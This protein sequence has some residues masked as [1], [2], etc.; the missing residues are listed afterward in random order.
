MLKRVFIVG[1]FLAFYLICGNCEPNSKEA[2]RGTKFGGDAW[3]NTLYFTENCGQWPPEILYKATI[4]HVSISFSQGEVYFQFRRCSTS[5]RRR[6]ST[7]KQASYVS[8]L[9]SKRECYGLNKKFDS[10]QV[11]TVKAKLVGS[12]PRVTVCGE[13]PVSYKCNYFFGNDAAMWYTDVPNYRAVTYKNIYPGIDLRYY[14]NGEQMEYDFIVSSGVDPSQIELR[15]EGTENVFVNADG[16]LVLETGI[17]MIKG[18][19]PIVYQIEDGVRSLVKG[20]YVLLSKNTIGFELEGNY[21]RSS[22]IVIDPVLSFSTF[23]GG[24]DDDEAHDIAV[25]GNGDVYI[26]GEAAS[27]NFPVRNAYQGTY[28]GYDDVFVTKFSSDGTLIYSTY[29]GGTGTEEGY[30]IAVDGSGAVYL[31]GET[32]SPDF[33]MVNAYD[34]TI[35]TNPIYGYPSFEAFVTKLSPAGNSL[36]FSTYLGGSFDDWAWGIAVD[37]GGYTYIGGSTES[38]DFPVENA[39]DNSLGGT[40]D[41]FVAKLSPFGNSLVYSTYLGGFAEEGCL[42]M[43]VNRK[44]DVYVAGWTTSADFPV[45][46]AYDTDLGGSSDGFVAR[47]SSL[48]SL[49]YSTY[50]GGS[51]DDGCASIAVGEDGIIYVA[52]GTN[53]VDFPIVN[54]YDP[55]LNDN[56]ADAFV[57]KIDSSGSVIL[58]STYLG[59]TDAEIV[60]DIDVS[61]SGQVYLTGFTSS[62]DFPLVNSYDESYNGS[63]DVFVSSLSS[64]GDELIYSTYL[65]GSEY[66]E[67]DGIVV[68]GNGNVF[69]SGWTLSSDFPTANAYDNGFNGFIDAFVAKIADVGTFVNDCRDLTRPESFS[70]SQNYPNPFNLQTQIEFVIPYTSKAKIEIFNVLGQ[71]I[72]TL[73][74]GWLTQGSYRITWDGSDGNGNEV[75]TGVYFCKLSVNGFTQARKMLLLK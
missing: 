32:D 8:T 27:S 45:M 53:S 42:K 12:N 65:G 16:E 47:F 73:L 5:L 24:T 70:L 58:Y 13:E 17:G 55:I 14:G 3:S 59:G 44:G 49:I 22:T 75:S 50:L 68:D 4:P 2:S 21:D 35:D 7:K 29:L 15:Y 67:G 1:I 46:G 69:I 51:G 10:V 25:D 23:L 19:K 43:A 41:V 48:G 57:T 6:C 52:G 11:V 30:G 39:Y 26:V 20:K 62:P 18:L 54:A 38:S 9:L 37:T 28:M 31:T 64:S 66:E 61:T 60:W 36:V 71:H 63:G 56:S 72:V 40:E 34:S 33:P 74:D